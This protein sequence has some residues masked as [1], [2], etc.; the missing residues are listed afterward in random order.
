MK[1]TENRAMIQ[2]ANL[3][4]GQ[5]FTLPGEFGDR[6]FTATEWTQ[7]GSMKTEEIEWQN[8]STMVLIEK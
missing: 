7:F 3:Q 8:P 4:N 6:E 5:K 2:M 1:N